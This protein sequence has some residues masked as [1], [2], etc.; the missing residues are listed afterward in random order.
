MVRPR[1]LM[2]LLPSEVKKPALEH[3][4]TPAAVELSHEIVVV[5]PEILSNAAALA[6]E[7]RLANSTPAPSVVISVRFMFHVS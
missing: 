1:K 7:L 4:V 5:L 3:A 2:V 6:G